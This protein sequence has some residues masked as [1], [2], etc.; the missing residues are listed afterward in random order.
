MRLLLVLLLLAGCGADD[1]PHAPAR[2]TQGV[3]SISTGIAPL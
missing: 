1:P 2:G 3:G